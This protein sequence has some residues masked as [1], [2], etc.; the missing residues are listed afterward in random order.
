[1]CKYDDWQRHQHGFT[2]PCIQ[3]T[4]VTWASLHRGRGFIL[5]IFQG[6]LEDALNTNTTEQWKPVVGF[7]GLYEVSDMGRVRSLD[8]Y[9]RHPKGGL[10]HIA[11][12]VLTLRPG[13]STSTYLRIGLCKNGVKS[14]HSVHRL[15]AMAFLPNPENKPQVNHKEKPK[16]DNR[17]SNLE[18]AT[19]PEDDAHKT[20]NG[21][22]TPGAKNGMAKLTEAQVIEIRNLRKQGWPLQEL[23]TR[24]GVDQSNISAIVLRKSWYHI[25]ES[26]E[27]SNV[28]A[29]VIASQTTTPTG[30][31]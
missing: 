12:C 26:A 14:Q 10:A 31:N 2:A 20:A 17:V 24:Y 18:W 16:T 13:T 23:A 6:H 25:P 7:E 22:D 1:M 9:I 30:V 28:P 4:A 19:R 8:R 5:E 29:S 27:G 11:G 3:K 15:V 21:W